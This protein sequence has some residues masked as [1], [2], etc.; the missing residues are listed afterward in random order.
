MHKAQQRAQVYF[1]SFLT[2]ACVGFMLSLSLKRNEEKF[3]QLKPGW[4]FI[5]AQSFGDQ[6][7][8]VLEQ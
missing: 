1:Y 8:V 2:D 6:A 7:S 5:N 4:D 3:Q